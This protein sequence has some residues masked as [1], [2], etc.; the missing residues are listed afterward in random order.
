MSRRNVVVQYLFII[1]GRWEYFTSKEIFGCL[2]FGSI[3]RILQCNKKIGNET[4]EKKLFS[5]AKMCVKLEEG[6]PYFRLRTGHEEG[7]L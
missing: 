1:E 5:S 4:Y 7:K 3:S 2:E 6:V